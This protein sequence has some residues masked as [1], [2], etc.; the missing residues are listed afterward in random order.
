MLGGKLP[1][2]GFLLW[3]LDSMA[4]GVSDTSDCIGHIQALRYPVCGSE[5]SRPAAT[6]LT[7]NDGLNP[8]RVADQAMS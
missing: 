6:A 7:V 4:S 3:G 8:A 2:S 1:E 5:P